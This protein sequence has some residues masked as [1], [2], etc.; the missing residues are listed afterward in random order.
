MPYTSAVRPRIGTLGANVHARFAAHVRTFLPFDRFSLCTIENEG[1]SLA[2]AYTESA[3]IQAF[4][5]GDAYPIEETLARYLDGSGAC[6]IRSDLASIPDADL[7]WAER[8]ARDAG[9]RCVGMIPLMA[10][11]DLVGLLHVFSIQPNAYTL[12][13]LAPL[14]LLAPLVTAALQNAR[15][16]DQAERLA[17]EARAGELITTCTLP[18]ADVTEQETLRRRQIASEERL[19]AVYHA[20]SGGVLVLD[21]SGAVVEV[22]AAAEEILGTNRET[23]IGF[24]V[25]L[26]PWSLT[27]RDGAPFGIEE[28][29]AAVALRERR[30]LRQLPLRVVRPDG[31]ERLV[32]LDAVPHIGPDGAVEQVV[33]SYADMTGRVRAEQALRTSQDLLRMAVANAPIVITM[34]DRDGVITFSEGR[35]L[36]RLGR[37]PGATVGQSAYALFRDTPVVL[38]CL[39]RVLGGEPC[40]GRVD[41]GTVLFETLYTP[42]YAGDGSVRGAISVSTDITERVRNEEALRASEVQFRAAF[43]GAPIGMS[44]LG[45]DGRF[46]QVNPAMCGLL[47]YEEKDFIGAHVLRRVAPEDYQAAKAYLQRLTE[48]QIES[49][50]METRLLR[51]DDSQIWVQVS[52]T[53]SRDEHDRPSHLV[54]QVQD[55]TA[56]KEAEAALKDEAARLSAIIEAQHAIAMAGLDLDE[57]MRLIVRFAA[58]L[59]NSTGSVL[60]MVAGD[61]MVYRAGEGALAGAEGTRLRRDA[62]LSGLC[63]RTGEILTSDDALVDPRVD[64]AACRRLGAGSL[65][66]VPLVYE[67]NTIG[68]LQTMHHETHAFGQRDVA[69]LQLMTGLLSSAMSMC[70]AF[71]AEQQALE[72]LMM[73]EERFRGMLEMAPVGACIVSEEGIF[74]SV[75]A[76]ICEL[77]GYTREELTGQPY[78]LVLPPSDSSGARAH[79]PSAMVIGEQRQGEGL[80]LTKDGRELTVL[81]NSVVFVG[82]DSQI[83]CAYFVFDITERKQFENNLAHAAH[84]DALTGLPNRALY[85][86]RLEQAL[87]AAQRQGYPLSILMIDLNGFKLVNDTLGHD[88]GDKLL[89]EVA[90]R[91]QSV[92]R[93][94]DTV[95]RLGGDEFGVVLPRSDEAGA[96]RV[97]NKIRAAL[98]PAITLDGREVYVGGSVGIAVFGE[99]GDDVESLQKAADLAMYAAKEDGGGYAVYASSLTGESLEPREGK[100]PRERR[101]SSISAELRQAIIRGD[102]RLHYQPLVSCIDG[103]VRRVEALVRWQHPEQGLLPPAYFITAAEQSGAITPLTIWVLEEALR[104]YQA[105]RRQGLELG[106]AVNVSLRT[107]RESQFP[108]LVVALLRQ[109]R[110]SP[111]DLTLEITENSMLEEHEQTLAV[112]RALADLGVRI[113]LDDVGIGHSS[114]EYITQLPVHELKVDRSFL[115]AAPGSKGHAVV[116]CILGLGA[117]LDLSVVV[118]GVETREA[119]DWLIGMG[120]EWAQ[121]YFMSRPLPPEALEIWYKAHPLLDPG[122]ES[123]TPWAGAS[124]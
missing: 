86:D 31:S 68:V 23:M 56:R 88:A 108:D 110:I 118:E 115:G 70:D 122:A 90:L 94:G 84:H 45:L 18:P 95:A 58:S 1:R 96:T 123:T 47:G 15:A 72:A 43:L 65:L 55:I 28:R 6:V 3:Q 80:V 116:C 33:V 59:T 93:S 19:R 35:G 83:H 97:A 22:N 50:T 71:A 37:A 21:A 105:W 99:H 27:H 62:S 25:Y 30:P 82:D 49:A 121:G 8:T 54:N 16:Q 20:I 91:L 52:S 7:C 64:A 39:H 5:I 92:V 69:T 57:V 87:L 53:V 111:G 85:H 78:T 34:V 61:E 76:S 40:S 77:Y 46:I 73:S 119:W 104:Q 63:A 2:I 13:D 32:E 17:P 74:E 100:E 120:C 98:A 109:Y 29:P 26:A 60:A 12:T 106:I 81:T 36:E 41:L 103:R 107:L 24:P 11:N 102:L 79:H 51:K 114:L 66:A 113:A 42:L 89:R 14:T 9:L 67:Q 10:E 48:G 38:D 75:N 124:G 44:L 4:T 117:A 112:L 101:R